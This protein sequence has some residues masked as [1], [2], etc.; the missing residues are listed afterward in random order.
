MVVM[1]A[2][3]DGLVGMRAD[4]FQNADHVL[5]LDPVPLDRDLL[6]QGPALELAGTRLQILVDLFLDPRERRRARGDQQ[7]VGE[8]AAQHHEREV[9]IRLG[10]AGAEREQLVFL[11]SQAGQVVDQQDRDRTVLEG[12]GRLVLKGGIRRG[13]LAVERAG[14]VPLLR[15]A[16]D[17]EDGLPLDVDARVVVV[18]ELEIARPWP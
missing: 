3:H 10:A 11:V 8:I 17:Q 4:P 1:A 14:V 7:L 13:S 15:L 18:I 5:G 9:G 2:D 16:P 12:V 6:A